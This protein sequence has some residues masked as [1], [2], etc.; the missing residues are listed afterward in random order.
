M[1]VDGFCHPFLRIQTN[2]VTLF[3][4]RDQSYVIRLENPSTSPKEGTGTV[5]YVRTHVHFLYGSAQDVLAVHGNRWTECHCNILF[6]ED[7]MFCVFWFKICMPTV[8]FL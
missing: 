7:Y 6:C 1:M 8:L 5:K 2:L 3:R 4:S